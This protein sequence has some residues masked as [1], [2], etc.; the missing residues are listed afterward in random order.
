MWPIGA[1]QH[2]V[3]RGLDQRPCEWNRIVERPPAGGYP[4]GAAHLNP[5]ERIAH[6]LEQLLE[7]LLIQPRFCTHAAHVVDHERHLDTCDPLRILQD[8]LCVQMQHHVPAEPLDTFEHTVEYIE[9]G[10]AAQMRDEIEA[11]AA[12][13]ACV[14]VGQLFVGDTAIDDRHAAIAAVTACDCIEHR[15]IVRAVAACLHDHTPARAE[16]IMQRGQALE[17][18]I[19]RRVAAIRRI[20]EDVGRAKYVAVRVARV[21]GQALNGS[22][23]MGIGR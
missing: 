15:G 8:V 14:E 20:R 12:H 3:G 10:R 9:I 2:A 5:C 19:G 23:G 11:H 6:Q 22:N 17:R 4:L 1:P 13:A 18:R 21:G 16:K 7:R